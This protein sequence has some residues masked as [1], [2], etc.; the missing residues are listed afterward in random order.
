MLPKNFNEPMGAPAIFEKQIEIKLLHPASTLESRIQV[1]IYNDDGVSIHAFP[2][3]DG[4]NES[5]RHGPHGDYHVHINPGNGPKKIVLAVLDPDTGEVTLVPEDPSKLSRNEM[6][7]LN[8]L[9]Q[10]ESK[11]I[12]KFSLY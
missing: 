11:Y 2:K 6:K 12:Y 1:E 9:S 10:R 8:N 5:A 4:S 7:A 3:G